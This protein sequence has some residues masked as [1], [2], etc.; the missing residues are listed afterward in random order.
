MSE[1]VLGEAGNASSE[2]AAFG[3]DGEEKPA[4]DDRPRDWAP[5]GPDSSLGV[6]GGPDGNGAPDTTT[7]HDGQMTQ[8]GPA[9]RVS[10][11]RRR[12]SRGGRGR[13]AGMSVVRLVRRRAC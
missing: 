10:R 3:R 5:V 9:T 7:D 1:P 11:R 2:P 8:D 4:L 12:G 6:A 13:H